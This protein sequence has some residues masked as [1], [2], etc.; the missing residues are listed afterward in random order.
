MLCSQVVS[1]LTS[2]LHCRVCRAHWAEEVAPALKGYSVTHD[3]PI[4][5][6]LCV[7]DGKGR[8]CCPYAAMPG[9]ACLLIHVPA[10]ANRVCVCTK[11]LPDHVC[12]PPDLLQ[13]LQW[14]PGVPLVAFGS[15]DLRASEWKAYMEHNNM[16]TTGLEK[17]R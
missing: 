7:L 14:A 16:D 13:H 8:C 15:H 17:R 2:P 1:V 10:G 5:K 4:P 11:S 12:E 9:D 6:L 3:I